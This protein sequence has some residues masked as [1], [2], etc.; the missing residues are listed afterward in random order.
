LQLKRILAY[1]PV[2]AKTQKSFGES[3]SLTVEREG[4][5][6]LDGQKELKELEWTV[7]S[8]ANAKNKSLSAFFF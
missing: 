8:P 2:V 3:S 1:W 5:T 6:G 4:G 7:I